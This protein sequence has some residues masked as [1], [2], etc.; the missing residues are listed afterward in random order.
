VFKYTVIIRKKQIFKEKKAG[1]THKNTGAF[2]ALVLTAC[3]FFYNSDKI[4]CMEDL[5]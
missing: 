5:L 1:G 3:I 2:T 4:F